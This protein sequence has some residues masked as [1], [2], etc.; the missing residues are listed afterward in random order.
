MIQGLLEIPTASNVMQYF[1]PTVIRL[2]KIATDRIMLIISM[3]TEIVQRQ[4]Y[5]CINNTLLNRDLPPSVHILLPSESP[6]K[7]DMH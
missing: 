5:P 4:T 3:N 1:M 2:N 7:H 6:V